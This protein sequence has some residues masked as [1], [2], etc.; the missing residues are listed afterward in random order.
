[1]KIL[2]LTLFFFSFLFS[3]DFE[4]FIQVGS[5]KKSETLINFKEIA[6]ENQLNYIIRA[7][8]K[9]D[10]LFLEYLLVHIKQKK[11]QRVI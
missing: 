10:V 3:S 5:T 1:M 9:N 4:Y 8:E 11:K 2:I 6:N 7:R